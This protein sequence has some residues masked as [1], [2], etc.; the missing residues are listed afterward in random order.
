[1]D[2]SRTSVALLNKQRTILKLKRGVSKISK[3]RI[4]LVLLFIRAV[5]IIVWG[6]LL[7]SGKSL[8]LETQIAFTGIIFLSDAFDGIFSRR[9]VS[10]PSQY[11]FRIADS[12]VDKVGILFFLIV[13]L[14][15]NYLPLSTAS[16]IVIYNIILVLPPVVKILQGEQREY[17]LIQATFW[18][19]FYAC[20]VGIY[21]LSSI[22]TNFSFKYERI[23]LC[24]F[25]VIGIL[26]LLSHLEKIRKLEE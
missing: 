15:L 11:I 16:A 8:R 22:V 2:S 23:I 10:K 5:V 19:R 18:S 26:S 6:I 12:F 17:C 13:L 20:S 21:C 4:D 1:M 7:L 3:Y 25:I 9:F 14:Q 24:Y